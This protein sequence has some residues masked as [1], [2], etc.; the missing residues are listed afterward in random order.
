MNTQVIMLKEKVR[1]LYLMI[2]Q[3]YL[4]ISDCI[5]Y[6]R[7]LNDE[8]FDKENYIT[9]WELYYWIYSY[10][11]KKLRDDLKKHWDHHNGYDQETL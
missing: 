4:N 10:G 3:A 7:L 1:N 6:A 2:R 9:W 5:I 8:V 11:P